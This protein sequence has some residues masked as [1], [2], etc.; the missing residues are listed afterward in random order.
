MWPPPSSFVGKATI[1]GEAASDCR[2]DSGKA[3]K[4]AGNRRS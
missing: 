1:A 2:G 4:K 3:P